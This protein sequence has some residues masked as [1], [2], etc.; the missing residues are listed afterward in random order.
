MSDLR[1]NVTTEWIKLTGFFGHTPS[2]IP[3]SLFVEGDDD[4]PLWTEAVKPYQSKY[5]IK[6]ITN[7]MA[8]QNEGNGK[9]I[10]L[11]MKGL[12]QSKVIAIDADYDLLIDNY[13]Q[14]TDIVRNGEYIVNTTWY[15]VEN[16]LL[17]K[18]KSL[19]LLNSFSEASKGWY[20]DYLVKVDEKKYKTP[21]SQFGEILNQLHIQ[22]L[23]L[24][25]NFTSITVISSQECNT[26]IESIEKKLSNMH[27][28]GQNMWK[29]MR[30]HNLWNTIVKPVEEK[31]INERVKEITSKQS[32][33]A[34]NRNAALNQLGIYISVKDYLDEDFYSNVDGIQIPA[35]TRLKLD[36][37]FH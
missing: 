10:L 37:L 27:C 21:V 4:V 17:Q 22:K 3:V 29:V 26:K 25:G 2:R 23:A 32:G 28:A 36:S 7:K 19:P 30:G 8:N 18:T 15:S 6:V 12:G 35:E 31:R 34:F 20:L 24:R 33:S 11:S 13:S 14:Y 16:I 1:S 5:D 9:A